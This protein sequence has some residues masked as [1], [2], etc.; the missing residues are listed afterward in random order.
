MRPATVVVATRQ[1]LQRR[2]LA[3]AIAARPDLRAVGEAGDGDEAA[4]LIEAKHPDVALL[5]LPMGGLDGIAL[6]KR[7]S[8]RLPEWRTRVV[9][10]SGDRDPGL[11]KR[12]ISAGAAGYLAAD[13]SEDQVC[14]AV[15]RVARGGTA[16][17]SLAA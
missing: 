13:S 10:L 1:P 5:E 14:Q 7:I 3:S 16:L 12:A 11:A 15:S 4:T 2:R 9:L 6:C 17:V 8:A